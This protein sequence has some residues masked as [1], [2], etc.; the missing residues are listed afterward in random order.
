[1]CHP[2]PLHGFTLVELLVVVAII[3]LLIA[4]LLPGLKKAREAAT[5]AVCMS[6][7]HQVGIAMY[8]YAGDYNGYALSPEPWFGTTYARRER[9][10]P[11][12]LMAGK[13]LADVRVYIN[14][15]YGGPGGGSGCAVSGVP[16][17]NVFSCPALPPPHVPFAASG[18]SFPADTKTYGSSSFCYGMRG[19]VLPDASK[20]FELGN[21]RYD[22]EIY[23][24]PYRLPKMDTLSR[25]GPFMADTWSQNIS[26]GYPTQTAFFFL[27]YNYWAPPNPGE[28]GT[29]YRRHNDAAS[30]WFPDN[31][32]R[33]MNEGAIGALP[34]LLK[35]PNGAVYSSP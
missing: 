5:G 16:E 17:K 26:W 25:S 1:M 22:G 20:P 35:N 30:I 24:G 12:T 31:S 10:W 33:V 8:T 21:G 28:I 6:N 14:G 7:M 19:F 13:Y 18:T 27:D 32:V 34:N 4:I 2:R 23:N 11:D 29:I 3:A 15:F 9:N